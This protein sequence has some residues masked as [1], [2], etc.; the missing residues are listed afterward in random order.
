MIPLSELQHT[1]ATESWSVVAQPPFLSLTTGHDYRRQMQNGD[2][3]TSTVSYVIF[4]HQSSDNVRLKSK[5]SGATSRRRFK[6]TPDFFSLGVSSSSPFSFPGHQIRSLANNLRMPDNG[7]LYISRRSRPS[8]CPR[9]SCKRL[10]THIGGRV[11]RYYRQCHPPTST[12][13]SY[14]VAHSRWRSSLPILSTKLPT[15]PPEGVDPPIVLGCR[16]C[17]CSLTLEVESSD[18]IDNVIFYTSRR[19]RPSTSPSVFAYKVAHSHWRSSLPILSTKSSSTPPEGVDPPPCPPYSR[20]RSV[21]H[22]CWG[23]SLPIL[24]TVSSSTPPGGVDPLPCPP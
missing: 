6:T 23:S 15:T 9:L 20:M 24:S 7:I 18:T 14:V 4:Y 12:S 10:L 13:P 16:V 11:F 5:T 17:G 8:N 21:A 1:D 3:G 2:I 19:S 22:S